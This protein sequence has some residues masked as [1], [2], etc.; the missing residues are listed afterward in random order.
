MTI[1]EFAR[2]W[3]A[4]T[5]TSE[6]ETERCLDVIRARNDGLKAFTLVMTD[7]ARQQARQADRDLAAGLDRGP[8]HG[9]PLSVKDLI[10]VR[11]TVTTAASAVRQNAPA[12][13]ADAPA[14][15]RLR[16]AGAVFV[17][18]TNLHEFALGTT[19][20]DSAFGAVK[21]PLDPTRSAGGS[22]GGSA[23]S[24]RT[25]MALGS[26]GTDT[27]GSIRIPAAACGIVGLKPSLGE[28]DTAGV[29][30]L[31]PRLDHV[32]PL[33]QSVGDAW[34]LLNILA[35][36]PHP[37]PRS[38]A[39]PAE[40]RLK[41]LR[42]YF[43]DLMDIDVADAFDAALETLRRAGVNVSNG[44]ITHAYATAAVY[45]KIAPR[46]AFRQHQPTLD[47]VPEKYTT[48][49]RQ[50]LEL[51]RTISDEEF[52]QALDVQAVLRDEVNATLADCDA[53]VLPTLPIPAPILGADT[54]RIGHLQE[55]VR[56]MTL[57]NTQLFNLTGHPAISLPCGTTSDGLPVGLQLV[58]AQGRTD[59]LVR[60][61]LGCE[62]LLKSRGA[63]SPNA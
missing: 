56:S 9:V 44:S 8:L 34:I 39:M 49:V 26:V 11:G 47:A 20:E 24:V 16:A 27:G 62:L 6:D 50:R 21:N 22:S 10:D 45:L 25:G 40:I 15:A 42:P 14:I 3:R 57:R 32:G 35:G 60:I 59:A 23:V 13:P 12:A 7:S 53:L 61:A 4:R 33:A 63:A 36:E 55:P 17:G 52:V 28:V 37:A 29:I 19:S 2:A 46:E 5:I 41:L 43:C 38:Q 30:P 48:A 18:K 51:G 54:V 31:S 1:E 58:G